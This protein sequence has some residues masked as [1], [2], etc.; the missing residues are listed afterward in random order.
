MKG[1]NEN[2]KMKIHHLVGAALVLA[3]CQ[4]AAQVPAER[5]VKY[6]QSAYYLMGQHLSQMNLMLKGDLP[7]NK[8]A[9]ELNAETI[10][11]MGRIVFD[12][13]P[14]GSE[15]GASKAKPELWKEV[16]RFKQLSH[17]AQAE[18]EKL[19]AA[20]KTGD[21]QILKAR[22]SDVSKSCKACHDQYKMK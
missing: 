11:M 13:F 1:N 18:M 4:A 22:F 8:A 17:S 21:M 7:F 9:V 19:R 20:A 3:S 15:G 6:R 12:A 14:A 5:A 16:D 10:E 2:M